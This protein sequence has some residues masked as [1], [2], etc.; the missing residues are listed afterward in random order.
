MNNKPIEIPAWIIGMISFLLSSIFFVL[1]VLNIICNAIIVAIVCFILSL[2][3][4]LP[5]YFYLIIM[6]KG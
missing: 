1:C 3:L 6:R 5:A 2:V 4:S